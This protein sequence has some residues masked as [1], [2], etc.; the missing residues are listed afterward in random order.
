MAGRKT[1]FSRAKPVATR[2]AQPV[3]QPAPKKPA[4]VVIETKTLSPSEKISEAISHYL[5]A[6]G[7]DGPR[8][9]ADQIRTGKLARDDLRLL[10]L[11]VP[12]S[13]GI[14]ANRA[15]KIRSLF[16]FFLEDM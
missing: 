13:N 10:R 11:S 6:G 14:M 8:Q 12:H 4:P 1:V 16:D 2:P 9:I 15:D 7:A 3:A 5:A